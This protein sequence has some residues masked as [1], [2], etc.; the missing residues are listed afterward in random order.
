MYNEKYLNIKIKS[1]SKI[2]TNFH[3]NEMLK[4]GCC[5][6]S[7]NINRLLSSG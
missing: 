2:N 5:C 4:E 1:Y 6:V 3:E 7:L